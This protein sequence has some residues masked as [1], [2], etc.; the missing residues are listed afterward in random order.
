MNACPVPEEQQPLNEFKSLQSSWFFGWA[1]A[2]FGSFV[3]PMGVIW[4]LGWFI[5][6]PV[7]A[8]SFPPSKSLGHFILMAGGSATIPLWIVLTQL[9]FSWRYIR[10]RLQQETIPYEESGWFDGQRWRKPEDILVRDRLIVTYQLQPFLQRLELFFLGLAF[11]LGLA[12]LLWNW[13]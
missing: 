12:I 13:V 3:W 8:A 4:G 6:A 7:T 10:D 2:P 1:L 11:L 9:Y 5:A